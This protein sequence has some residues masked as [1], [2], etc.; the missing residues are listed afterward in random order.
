MLHP[1]MLCWPCRPPQLSSLSTAPAFPARTSPS[2]A[3]TGKARKDQ[4]NLTKPRNPIIAEPELRDFTP[5][6]CCSYSS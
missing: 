6:T 2:P 4:V 5:A 1:E 3:P